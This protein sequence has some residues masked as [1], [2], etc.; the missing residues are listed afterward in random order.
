MPARHA[1][2]DAALPPEVV[3]VDLDPAAGPWEPSPVLDPTVLAHRARD[4]DLVHVHFGFDHLAATALVAFT[5]ALREQGV[6]LVLTVHDVRNPHH[7]RRTTGDEHLAVLL[8]AAAAVLTL[9]PGAAA[10]ITRRWGVRARV[11]EHPGVL[12][13]GSTTRPG[14]VGLHLKSLRRNVLEPRRVVVAALAGA[15]AGGGHLQVDVHPDVAEHPELAGLD[16][17]DGLDLRVH[18]RFDDDALA[19]HLR[20][21]HVS[22][23]AQRFGSH[24]GWLEA[25]RDAG[26]AVVAPSSG[27]HAEQWAAVHTY[28]HDEEHGLDPESLAWAVRT[29]VATPSPAPAD[30]VWRARQQEQVRS[31]HRAVYTDVL[32][33]R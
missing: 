24:S 9:T 4:L 22:V 29:A 25:C 19:D 26:T 8:G 27:F 28:R 33:P 16:T 13:P 14:V 2:L 7:D 17:L 1:Y 10:E 31:A 18:E 3:R 30:P 5:T 11:V 23:L 32:A 21:L 15:R 12:D 20:G 6:P